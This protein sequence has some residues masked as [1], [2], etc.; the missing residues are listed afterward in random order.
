MEATFQKRDI[1]PKITGTNVLEIL[2]KADVFKDAAAIGQ[3]LVDILIKDKNIDFAKL[4]KI[5]RGMGSDTYLLAAPNNQ[6][7][8]NQKSLHPI[9]KKETPYCLWICVN[10][11]DDAEDTMKEFNIP[12]Y[13]ENLKRLEQ[14]GVITAEH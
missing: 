8:P 5:Y 14:T 12:S 1:T 10:G 2:Q 6:L 3:A 13:E 11:E 7:Q 9:T 4:E